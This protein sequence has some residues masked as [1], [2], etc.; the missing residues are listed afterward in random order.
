MIPALKA[1]LAARLDSPGWAR[2]RPPLAA[3]GA[4]EAGALMD[5]LTARGRAR[6]A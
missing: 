3:L 1:I 2:T 6:A 5:A 4:A